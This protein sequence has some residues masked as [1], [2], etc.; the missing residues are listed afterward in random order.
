[1]G[2][3]AVQKIAH[4]ARYKTLVCESNQRRAAALQE[5]GLTVTP[6]MDAVRQADFVVLAV[7]D[8]LI[9]KLSHE[10]VPAMKA[11]STLIMLDAAAAYIDLLPK[12]DSVT[13]MITH[14]CH[15]PFFT[16][17]ATV[18][19]RNDYFGGV[20]LQDIIV[21]FVSGTQSNF[22]AG[23]ALCRAI[24]APVRDVYAVTPAQFAMLEPAM[25]ELVVAT[26]AA[27]MK[28]SL[29][30]AVESGVPAGAA[31]AFIA[32]HARIAMAIVFGAES[33]P[34]SDAAKIAIRWGMKEVVQ[35]DWKKVFEPEVLRA[36]IH[37][38]LEDESE[39]ATAGD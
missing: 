32:G 17:Q 12:S 11:G 27:L 9:G 19:A 34:F 30:V 31:K 39:A 28:A 3:R 21:S 38:M 14:P 36:A 33:S 7:P 18:E 15:P 6:V 5:Q 20:A 22:E 25:S 1:M 2:E 26:A 8:A 13:Q 37:V 16:E 10:M 29:D 4:D 24:F 23:T 35:P